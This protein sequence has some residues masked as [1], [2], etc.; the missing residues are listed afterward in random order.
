MPCKRPGALPRPQRLALPRSRDQRKAKPNIRVRPSQ[1][2]PSP[3][4]NRLALTLVKLPA[5][6]GGVCADESEHCQRFGVKDL[7]ASPGL[8]NLRKPR[9]AWL[10]LSL[11]PP[12]RDSDETFDMSPEEQSKRRGSPAQ[13][14]RNSPTAALPPRVDL[15]K[16]MA[17]NA[18]PP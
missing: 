8:T 16:P 7:P 13:A 17:E 10:S 2:K 18:N 9:N 15:R 3:V 14:G 6:I 5:R 1:A 11:P 4:A 12:T